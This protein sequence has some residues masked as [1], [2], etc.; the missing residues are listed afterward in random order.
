MYIEIV[1]EFK[2]GLMKTNYKLV[3]EITVQLSAF[4]MVHYYTSEFTSPVV[5]FLEKVIHNIQK[6]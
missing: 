2:N 5:I 1:L 4:T 6:A 3:E